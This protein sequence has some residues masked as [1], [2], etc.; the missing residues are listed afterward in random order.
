[1]WRRWIFLYLAAFIIIADQLTKQWIRNILP[2][3]ASFPEVMRVTIIHLQNTGAAFGIFQDSSTVLSIV[4]LAGIIVIFIF[5]RKVG[6]AS[7]L[8]S[9][10]LGMVFGGA[11]GNLIDR[12][13]IGHV[14]DFIYIRLWGETYW[15]AFNVA[16]SCISIGMILL[17]W[18][19]IR[20]ISKKDAV[21]Q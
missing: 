3:G 8:G 11:L 12:I 2:P 7:L 10:S 19:M 6:M 20:E 13:R 18:F 5:Y 16:D 17:I 21:K 9:I 15:P 4:A 1:M 14:T